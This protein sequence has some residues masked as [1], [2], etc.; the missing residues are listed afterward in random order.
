MNALIA[1]LLAFPA[2]RLFMEEVVI[3]LL[4]ELLTKS[5]QDPEFRKKFLTLSSQLA[6]ATT[7]EGKRA[8]LIQ[9]RDLRNP[10]S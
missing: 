6:G 2:I 3:K 5:D 1:G 8:I 7:E 4:S 10:P 9:I